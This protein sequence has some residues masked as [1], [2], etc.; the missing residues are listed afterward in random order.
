MITE[1]VRQSSENFR[2]IN[3]FN[4]NNFMRQVQLL[5]EDVAIYMETSLDQTHSAGK[6]RSWGPNPAGWKPDPMLFL[7]TLMYDLYKGC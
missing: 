7:M 6:P 5:D 2:Y 1:Y 3:S 4:F